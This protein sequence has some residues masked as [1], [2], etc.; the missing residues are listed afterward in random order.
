LD[1]YIIQLN[2]MTYKNTVINI[3]GVNISLLKKEDVINEINNFLISKNKHY[4]NT[5]NPEI[6]LKSLNDKNYKTILN[7]ADISIADGFGIKLAGLTFK[8][9]I[10]RITGAD[11][12]KDILKIAENKKYKIAVLNR[13]KGLSSI[14]DIEISL[15]SAYPRLTFKVF[16]SKLDVNGD[17]LKEIYNFS[18]DIL[19]VAFGAPYQEKFIY[20]NLDILESVKL[21]LGIGGTFD[22]LTGRIKRAPKILRIIGLEWL[23]RIFQA[24]GKRKL[25]RLKRI[26]NAVIVFS[27]KFIKWRLR[28]NR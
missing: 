12:V 6:I 17:T 24:K 3:L 20:N 25:W 7:R 11:L 27:Y 10:P 16:N 13:E 5:P 9:N 26:F 8:K 14:K 2:V 23:W 19:F 18:P 1:Q 22:F 15:K 21:A 28:K 4:I